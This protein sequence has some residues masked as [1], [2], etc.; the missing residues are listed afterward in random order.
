MI[1]EWLQDFTPYFIAV[2]GIISGAVVARINKAGTRENQIIDQ[3]QEERDAIAQA[4]KELKEDF[5][6]RIESLESKLN[7]LEIRE[8][9]FVSYV[10]TLQ[11]WINEGKGPPPPPWPEALLPSTS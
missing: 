1:P 7:G 5:E 6:K 8:R 10:M 3:V 11:N 4:K 2:A 9:I